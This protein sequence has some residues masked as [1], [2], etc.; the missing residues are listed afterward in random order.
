MSDSIEGTIEY[1]E[2]YIMQR[3]L[4]GEELLMIALAFQGGILRGLKEA[5]KEKEKDNGNI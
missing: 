5:E 1:I 2:V 4:S 3:K